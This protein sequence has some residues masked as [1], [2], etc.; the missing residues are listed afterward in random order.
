LAWTK[1][2]IL[3]LA[4]F[5]LLLFGAWPANAETII[6]T[7]QVIGTGTLGGTAFTNS[8]II[9][10]VTGDTAN[11]PQAFSNLLQ[12]NYYYN[13]NIGPATLT[14]GGIGTATKNDPIDALVFPSVQEAQFFDNPT[15]TAPMGPRNLG[16]ASYDLKTAIGP[17]SGTPRWATPFNINTTSGLLELRALWHARKVSDKWTMNYPSR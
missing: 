2:T 6:Y 3:T 1:Y 14:V 7:E 11:V 15:G 9:I 16:F 17:V 12:S 10:T 8:M 13:A 4:A 5:I